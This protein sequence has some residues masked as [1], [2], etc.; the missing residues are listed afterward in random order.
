[1]LA[2]PSESESSQRHAE[3]LDRVGD[4]AEGFELSQLHDSTVYGLPIP[5]E[6]QWQDID[7]QG[8]QTDWQEGALHYERPRESS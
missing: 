7:F 3:D 4:H 8:S 6:A 1:M 2:D 5:R